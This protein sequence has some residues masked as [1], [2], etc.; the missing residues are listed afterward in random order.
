L[1]WKKTLET[2]LK[3]M[4]EYH[5]TCI[6]KPQH[7]SPHEH[8]THIGNQ[9]EKWRFTREEAIKMIE[10]D[11]KERF[12]TTAPADK[13]CYVEVVRPHGKAPYL[14]AHA[15]GT[16]NDNLLKQPECS[17]DCVIVDSGSGLTSHAPKSPVELRG[18]GRHG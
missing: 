3:H 18:G 11:K 2:K 1:H 13:K 14:R 7:D 10:G 6:N 8:I 15:D 5:I 16:P 12:Y 4:A 9:K 17:T